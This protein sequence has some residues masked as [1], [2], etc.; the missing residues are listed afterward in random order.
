MIRI[1]DK[2][3]EDFI[4]E[5][6]VTAVAEATGRSEGAVRVWKHR[7]RFPREAW[8]ELN[9]AYPELTLDVLRKLSGQ[10]GAR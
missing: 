7:K 6:G 3:V 1:T 4:G 8:L 10:K 2:F 5:K 9:K